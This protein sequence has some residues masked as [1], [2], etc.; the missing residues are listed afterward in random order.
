MQMSSTPRSAAASIMAFIP[1]ISVSQPSSPNRFAAAYLFARKPSKSSDHANRSRMW[2]CSEAEYL[3][4]GGRDSIQALGFDEGMRLVPCDYRCEAD[5][6]ASAYVGLNNGFVVSHASDWSQVSLRHD[7]HLAL[8]LMM[9]IS[10]YVKA[11]HSHG[12]NVKSHTL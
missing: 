8:E 9:V 1:G 10:V 12:F 11:F 3:R 5:K 6:Y 4:R 2:S 7:V